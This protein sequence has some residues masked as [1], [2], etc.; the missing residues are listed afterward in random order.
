MELARTRT[1]RGLLFVLL[2]TFVVFLPALFSQFPMDDEFV[3]KAHDPSGKPRPMVAELQPLGEYF[4]SHYWRDHYASSALYR[5]VTKFSFALVYNAGGKFLP[6]ELEA[7]PQHLVNLLLHL[8]A[9][10]LVFALTRRVTTSRLAPLLAALVFGVHTIHVESVVSIV[11]RAELFGF[12][13]GAQALLL[14]IVSR[15]RSESPLRWLARLL[16]VVLAFLAFA[17]KESALAW[18]PFFFVFVF[19]LRLVRRDEDAQSAPTWLQTVGVTLPG[20]VLFFWL[21]QRMLAN[22]GEIDPVVFAANPLAEADTA[23][24]LLTA[25]EILGFAL[26][27]VLFPLRLAVDHGPAVFSLVEGPLDLGFLAH[28]GLLCL[29]LGTGAALARTQP[30]A[31]LAIAAYFGFS[32]ITSNLP[33]PIGTIYAERLYYTPSLAFSFLVA[34][35][36]ALAENKRRLPYVLVPLILWTG[37]CAVY[38][39]RRSVVFKDTYTLAEHDVRVRPNSASLQRLAGEAHKERGDLAGAIPFFRRA[40]ELDPGFAPGWLNLGALLQM[41]GDL[42]EAE[43]AYRRGLEVASPRLVRERASLHKNLALVLRA[44][45]RRDQAIAEF[46]AALELVPQSASLAIAL[47][48]TLAADGDR[49]EAKKLCRRVLQN[50]TASARDK[51]A[52]AVLLRRLR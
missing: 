36:V 5:P 18:A 52:A 43:Q 50:E 39:F 7:L 28:A 46:V 40:G 31:L 20:L 45:G 33:F 4:G 34:A 17:S 15:E 26:L 3:A 42:E 24:R 16:A 25:V 35:L 48:R 37:H 10:C 29:V 6:P 27:K 41:S 23:T 44:T 49:D 12:C 11:G 21:R 32:F 38:A 9:V 22:V 2:V 51:Q 19:A 13:F 47:A 1:A 30:L 14:L 8:W